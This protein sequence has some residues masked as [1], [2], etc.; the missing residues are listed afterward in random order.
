[1]V[2]AS[3]NQANGEACSTKKHVY[4]KVYVKYFQKGGRKKERERNSIEGERSEGERKKE[5][6]LRNKLKMEEK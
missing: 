6:S 4:D 3:S 1:L 5:M 2:S